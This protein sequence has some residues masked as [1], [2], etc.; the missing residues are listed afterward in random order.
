MVTLTVDLADMIT[1]TLLLTAELAEPAIAVIAMAIT[2][3]AAPAPNA[4]ARAMVQELATAMALAASTA[5]EPVAQNAATVRDLLGKWTLTPRMS[6]KATNS[7]WV[8]VKALTAK[9]LLAAAA[10]KVKNLEPAMATA[11]VKELPLAKVLVRAKVKVLVL[12]K[13]KVRSL[14]KAKVLFPM[15]AKILLRAKVL[16]LVLAK[17]AAAVR[18]P[19]PTRWNR[20]LVPNPTLPLRELLLEWVLEV[21]APMVRTW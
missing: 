21:R 7:L 4:L 14:T 3:M 16:D 2:A 19:V 13:A 20:L 15:K 10:E 12:E 1:A 18:N 17:I 11:T 9:K 5:A 8:L 6:D